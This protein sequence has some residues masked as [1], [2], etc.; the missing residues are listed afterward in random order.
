MR[1]LESSLDLEYSLSSL[2]LDSDTGNTTVQQL[3]YRTES[4]TKEG[5]VA[6]EMLS[7]THFC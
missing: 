4:K 2:D 1:N 5:K 3:V 6:T 7:L